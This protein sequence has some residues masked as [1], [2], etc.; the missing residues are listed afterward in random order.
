VLDLKDGKEII[1][2]DERCGKQLQLNT[3][4]KF[5]WKSKPMHSGK[6]LWTKL[7]KILER[8]INITTLRT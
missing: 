8:L 3:Y 4:L 7:V 5:L 2:V 1:V 6:A